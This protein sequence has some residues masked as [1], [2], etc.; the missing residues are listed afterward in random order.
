MIFLLFDEPFLNFLMPFMRQN[1]F[2]F[3]TI[4]ALLILAG[5]CKKPPEFLPCE[6][7]SF[8][9]DMKCIPGGPFLR[10]SN[11]PGMEEDTHKSIGD[12]SP[13]ESVVLDTFYLDTY[14][15]TYAQYQD[16]VHAKGCSPAG[17]VYK[18]YDG[19]GMPMLGLNWF[20]ARDYCHWKNRRLPTEAEWE[21]ASRGE[22]GD[23]YPWG[24]EPSTCERAIIQENGVKGCGTG[25]TWKVGSRPAYRYGLFDMAGNAWEWV[26]DWYSESYTACGESCRGRNP[27][28]PCQGNDACPGHEKKMVKGG[29]WWW[30]GE[31][32]RASNRR[33]HFPINQPY[34]HFGFRCAMDAPRPEK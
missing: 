30:D 8:P 15:V 18:D 12:E 19:P 20:Q 9:S 13:Q 5:G 1:V 27:Q 14:E 23:L 24:N 6:G 16:C 29:A 22:K 32:S 11:S 3:I 7:A 25:K 34:H 33:A 21:K 2:S 31:Y 10:G 4:T 17:P 28:G 26:N